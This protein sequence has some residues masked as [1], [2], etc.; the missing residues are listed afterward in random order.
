MMRQRAGKFKRI[1]LLDAKSL[2]AAGNDPPQ[3]LKIPCESHRLI[4]PVK[5]LYCKKF[6]ARKSV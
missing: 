5:P 6:Y 3:S 4:R 1:D 2:V